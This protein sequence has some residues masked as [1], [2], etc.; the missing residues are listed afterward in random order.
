[1]HSKF[2]SRRQANRGFTLMEMMITVGILTLVASIAIPS[3]FGQ[4]TKS[5][6]TEAKVTLADAA[7]KLARCFSEANTYEFSA[8]TLAEACPQSSDLNDDPNV[9][10]YY[11]F[12]IDI[13]N[14]G[15]TYVLT[16]TATGKQADRDSK[17][18]TLTLNQINEKKQTPTSD[19]KCW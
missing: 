16:A 1:M 8:G 7:Q 3:Y 13:D 17:C 18:Q 6:R 10:D 19:Y 5:R 9:S 2:Y 12:E 4:I 11:T 14:N 15:T